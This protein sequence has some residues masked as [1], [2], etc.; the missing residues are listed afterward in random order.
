MSIIVLVQFTGLG[1]NEYVIAMLN[2]GLFLCSCYNVWV[3]S[4]M[5]LLVH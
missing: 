2:T 5:L 3:D 4:S 1:S